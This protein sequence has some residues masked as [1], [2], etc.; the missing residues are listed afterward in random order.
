MSGIRHSDFTFETRGR[1]TLVKRGRTTIGRMV[2]K[3]SSGKLHYYSDRRGNHIF[4]SGMPSVMVAKQE[5]VA[6]WGMDVALVRHLK[7]LGVKRTHVMWKDGTVKKDFSCGIS[8]W[9]NGDVKDY[10]H[11]PQY[12]LKFNE[13]KVRD[14]T[15]RNILRPW[16]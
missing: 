14:A 10:G 9:E 11:T 6:A 5:K 8:K 12:F 4:L 13:F 2:L 15:T 7:K 16:R 3:E 1:A